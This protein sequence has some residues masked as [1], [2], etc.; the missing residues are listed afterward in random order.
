MLPPDIEEPLVNEYLG[1]NK[2]P[3]T[4]MAQYQEMMA[5]AL[6]VMPA[7]HVAHFQREFIC[8]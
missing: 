5:D 3:K 7:L 1:D 6:F 2:D 8:G 4:L